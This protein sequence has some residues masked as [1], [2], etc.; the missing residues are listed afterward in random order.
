M[1]P[2]TTHL[3]TGGRG[4]QELEALA[5]VTCRSR[6]LKC[7][8]VKPAC[9]R[10]VKVNWDCV[11]PESRRKPA[12]KRRN[13]RELEERLAQV[14]GLL[15]ES[16]KSTAASGPPAAGPGGPPIPSLGSRDN[17]T[18]NVE[19]LLGAEAG[20]QGTSLSSDGTTPRLPFAS[21]ARPQDHF[22]N[23]AFT[24]PASPGEIIGL[25]QFEFLPPVELMEEL[26]NAY[27]QRQHQFFPIVHPGRYF[28]SFYSVP[29]MRPPMCL[30]YA[31]WALASNGHE[32]YS[33]YHD[34]FYKRARQY[35]D[36]DEMRD[37][38]EHFVRLSHAQAWA[39]IATDEARSMLFT[40]AAMS[41]AKAIR[42]V[43][44]MGLHRIDGDGHAMAPTLAPPK[45]W[46]EV[47][48][49]R[50]TFWGV[51]SV[52]THASLSTGWPT[53]INPADVTTNL[54]ASEEAF[55]EGREETT[56]TLPEA[57]KGAS[58]TTFGGTII[59]CHIYHEIL[60]HIHRSNPN[61]RPED[62]ECGEFWK[63]HRELDNMLSSTFMFLPPAF[64]FPQNLKNPPAIHT[65]LNL[66]ASVICLHHAAIEKIDTHNLPESLR[67]ASQLR[68][69]LAAEEIVNIIR[70]TSHNIN[71]GYKSPLAALS[72]YCAASVYVYTAMLDPQTGLSDAD[73]SNLELI[74]QAMEAISRSH[75]IT[76]SFLQ[77]LCADVERNGL[78][79]I[80]RLPSLAE[81]RNPFGWP[82]SNIPLLARNHLTKHTDIQTPL[83]GRLPLEVQ[84]S[85]FTPSPAQ[86]QQSLD[87]DSSREGRNGPM[88]DC[89]SSNK[90]KRASPA[91]D[92]P[93]GATDYGPPSFDY[94]VSS[95]ASIQSPN[96]NG[97]EG[98]GIYVPGL[99]GSTGMSPPMASDSQAANL[100][101]RTNL[102]AS[103]SVPPN[104]DNTASCTPT[105]TSNSFA[106]DHHEITGDDREQQAMDDAG[107]Q[108]GVGAAGFDTPSDYV[109]YAQDADPFTQTSFEAST[110]IEPWDLL[111]PSN[112][113]ITWPAGDETEHGA[114]YE[115]TLS[116]VGIQAQIRQ[117]GFSRYE[118]GSGSY[119]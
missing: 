33:R 10:C 79:S 71:S 118:S 22:S 93:E 81:Y 56:C 2:D 62:V 68:L 38:G 66:H 84:T 19:T 108:S 92:V 107:S 60:A 44:M 63:K 31:I 34:V 119:G 1:E 96:K 106:K 23:I 67:V 89:N 7:D 85:A 111:T 3:E 43:Q 26:N 11:Y 94:V 100:P 5:C 105:E 76:R 24:A 88:A 77:Q 18:L 114:D 32:K 25:G 59:L 116:T 110:G 37:T 117:G 83:P 86:K 55:N 91:A 115:S 90:R 15:R 95:A 70:L 99:L 17:F 73:M 57:L 50:R 98:R 69:R 102:P 80:I 72:M 74:V 41:S 4:T 112:D 45:D 6:K 103:P 27:F 65:N 29:H 12:V 54:P 36:A 97:A 61:A 87:A 101:L 20:P 51:F 47:E 53:L 46:T 82:C 75:Y 49:R 21:E 52:D 39:L 64:R 35:A 40:R 113:D 78:G 16:G 30:Q 14:E 42:L 58:Y 109:P 9:G 104:G 13:V 28:Q 8:R 48:E